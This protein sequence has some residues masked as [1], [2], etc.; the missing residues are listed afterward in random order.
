[1]QAIA[2]LPAEIASR[3]PR[4]DDAHLV[5]REVVVRADSAGCTEGFLAAC[6]D[7]NVGFFVSA[8]CQCPGHG[9]HLR[10]HRDRGGVAAGALAQDG[11]ADGR[12]AVAEL[13]SLD[14]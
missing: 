12:C 13:T 10:R 14:R 6:R 4:G 8:R 11:G 7:R 5:E 1:M 2:Q 3:P 9:R